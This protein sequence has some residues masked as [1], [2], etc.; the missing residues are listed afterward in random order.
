[1]GAFSGLF[2]ALAPHLSSRVVGKSIWILRSIL[3]LF[4]LSAML[5]F[6]AALWAQR[7]PAFSGMNS[8][9]IAQPG[10]MYSSVA[11]LEHLNLEVNLEKSFRVRDEWHKTDTERSC[12]F[13]PLNTVH[14]LTVGTA[15]L[16]VPKDAK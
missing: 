13:A 4:A 5:V 8:Q 2:P 12:F 6:P 3:S 16:S 9:T 1:M 15:T 11:G 10:G 14:D 7:P